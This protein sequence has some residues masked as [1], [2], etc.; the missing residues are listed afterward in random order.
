M[1][2][3]SHEPTMLC[4]TSVLIRNGWSSGQLLLVSAKAVLLVSSGPQ[5]ECLDIHY[6]GLSA[7]L[8]RRGPLSGLERA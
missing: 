5:P 2:A 7:L 3:R 6:R 4:G 1:A 8:R